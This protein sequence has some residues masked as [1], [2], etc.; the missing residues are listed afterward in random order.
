MSKKKNKANIT[1]LPKTII[2]F[3]KE[4]R[5]EL[6]KVSWPTRQ[7]TIRYTIIVIAASLVVGLTIGS[8]DYILTILLEQ[9]I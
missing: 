4:A 7:T 2:K 9:T 5:D 8:F 6:K 1:Q 3:V